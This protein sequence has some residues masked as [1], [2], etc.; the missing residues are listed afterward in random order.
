MNSFN[1]FRVSLDAAAGFVCVA[2]WRNFLPHFLVPHSTWLEH[3]TF[4]FTI[5][6]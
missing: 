2:F 6:Q 3:D 5:L 1:L 4:Y